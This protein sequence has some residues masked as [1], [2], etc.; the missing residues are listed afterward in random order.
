[1]MQLLELEWSETSRYWKEARPAPRVR[2]WRSLIDG[3]R[4]NDI[5]YAPGTYCIEVYDNVADADLMER[6]V[7]AWE[8]LDDLAAQAI[9]YFVLE[10]Y[11]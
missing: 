11:P 2:I 1:M 4:S 6:E 8:K 3:A 9:L 5:Y 7:R 10:N